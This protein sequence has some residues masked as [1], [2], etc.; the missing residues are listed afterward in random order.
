MS[1]L[2]TQLAEVIGQ[3][4]DENLLL[5]VLMAHALK[6]KDMVLNA[7]LEAYCH[8]PRREQDEASCEVDFD[9]LGRIKT[10]CPED[11]SLTWG[12]ALTRCVMR[13]DQRKA[14]ALQDLMRRRV[15]N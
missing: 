4:D 5:V 9:L 15:A 13:G 3:L 11:E 2:D 10:V 12:R 1:D 14:A 6:R 8:I 7:A